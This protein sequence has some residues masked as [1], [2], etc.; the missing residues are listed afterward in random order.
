MLKAYSSFSL[1]FPPRFT[2]ASVAGRLD[3]NSPS[4]SKHE[5]NSNYALSPTFF[6]TSSAPATA[7]HFVVKM[8]T[9][10]TVNARTQQPMLASQRAKE[11]AQADEGRRPP[12]GAG[13]FPLG[14]KDAV[15]QWVSLATYLPA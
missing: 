14:Y 4:S 1:V 9:D 10:S 5:K 3:S 7:T 12:R 13:Y 2:L 11:Q 6:P 15:Y 8:S